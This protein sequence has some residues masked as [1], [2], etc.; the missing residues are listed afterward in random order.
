MAASAATTRNS[1]NTEQFMS[2][3]TLTSDSLHDGYAPR[4]HDD[5]GGTKCNPDGVVLPL[6]VWRRALLFFQGWWWST[7]RGEAVTVLGYYGPE[8]SPGG[9]QDSRWS[10]LLWIWRRSMIRPR[11][12]RPCFTSVT[13]VDA[14]A[15]NAVSQGVESAGDEV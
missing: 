3:T 6:D 11:S 5:V 10:K 8:V 7:A 1:P 2:T 14:I 15:E 13:P 12:L 4:P 9:R